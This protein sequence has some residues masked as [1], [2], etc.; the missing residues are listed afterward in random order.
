MVLWLHL[1]KYLEPSLKMRK[2]NEKRKNDSSISFLNRYPKGKESIYIIIW[3]KI[4]ID[5][6]YVE[7]FALKTTAT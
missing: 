6:I 5:I 1:V 7:K 3:S 4:A 2:I